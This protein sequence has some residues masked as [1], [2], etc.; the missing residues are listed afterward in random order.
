MEAFCGERRRPVVAAGA[1]ALVAA[2]S[3]ATVF[4]HPDARAWSKRLPLRGGGKILHDTEHRQLFVSG[5]TRNNDILVF[6]YDGRLKKRIG[7]LPGGSQ[8]TLSDGVLYVSLYHS[9]AIARIDTATLE[10]G[11]P[12]SIDPYAQPYQLAKTDNILW[13]SVGC[14]GD[15]P[16][17]ISVDLA[18]GLVSEHDVPASYS[19]DCASLTVSPND[20]SA[21]FTWQSGISRTE[22]RKYRVGGA[23]LPIPQP[24][25]LTEEDRVTID[26]FVTDVQPTA[27]GEELLVAGAARVFRTSDLV[28]TESYPH[29]GSGL[30]ASPDERYVAALENGIYARDIFLFSK[31]N[32]DPVFVGEM[33]DAYSGSDG[34]FPGGVVLERGARIYALGQNY[35]RTQRADL[36]V[37]TPWFDIK[38]TRRQ[39]VAPAADNGYFAWS[40]ARRGGPYHAYVQGA[41]KT[42][43]INPKGTSAVVGGMDGTRVA[44]TQHSNG[45]PA[46]YVYDVRTASRRKLGPAV[47]D[48]G[49]EYLPG[50]SGKWLVLGEGGLGD[51]RWLTLTNMKSGR[52]RVLDKNEIPILIPGQINGNW[53]VWFKC[54]KNGCFVY[55]YNIKTK[56]KVRL[57]RPSNRND[58]AP[59]V[60]PDGTVYWARGRRGCGAGVK[61]MRGRPGGPFTIVKDAPGGTDVIATFY[62]DDKR[63]LT[64]TYNCGR[65]QYDIVESREP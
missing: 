11:E 53:V 47:N 59:S 61:V 17:L 14:G 46:I 34:V 54:A 21:L 27:D 13:V 58:Y 24:P 33:A 65:R 64:E 28:E 2:L 8:M 56:K 31:G 51:R 55:R 44:Y 26:S 60:A 35:F 19:F 37:I 20:D 15:D 57:K 50:I 29:G 39:E 38:S 52:K 41:G 23:P 40:Q 6:D 43:R 62:A 32:V 48:G 5:D 42:R 4:P 12:I 63:L 16:Q 10:K 3:V 9:N 18:S 36:H 45:G 30:A 1:L 25:T 22:L 7:G 49:F